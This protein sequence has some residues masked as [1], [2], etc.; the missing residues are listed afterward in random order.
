MGVICVKN[1]MT[2]RHPSLETRKRM[3][4]SRM[5]NKN[6]L[7][8]IHTIDFKNRVSEC[9]KGVLF[10]ASHKENI[11]LSLI[12]KRHSVERVEKMKASLMKPEIRKI[13]SEKSKGNKAFL[14]RRHTEETKMKMRI[15]HKKKELGL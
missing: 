10:S 2:G 8:T 6:A 4:K 7:G 11:R 5:G 15:S 14:G 9:H 1:P 13:L 3:S 12:G